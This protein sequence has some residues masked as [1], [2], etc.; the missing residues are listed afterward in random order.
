MDGLEEVIKE[1]NRMQVPAEIWI[2]GSFLTEKID[3]ED[4]DIVLRI[5]SHVYD[6]GTAEQQQI[7]DW[8]A[9]NL[10]AS[11][12]CDSYVFYEYPDTH[13]AHAVGEWMHAYWLRQF[14]F[15]RA[16]DFKGMAR[17]RT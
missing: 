8:V 5:E 2:D 15:S 16:D 11:H 3:P 7:I 10:K 9:G 4:V 1:L 14:G 17:I 13:P 12:H 6:N